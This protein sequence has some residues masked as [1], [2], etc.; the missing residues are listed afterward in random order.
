MWL[1]NKTSSSRGFYFGCSLELP[2]EQ[3]RKE[4]RLTCEGEV[5]IPFPKKYSSWKQM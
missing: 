4:R 1:G 2:V 3:T 5:V